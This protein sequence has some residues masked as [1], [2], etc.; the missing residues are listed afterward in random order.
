MLNV[1]NV[2]GVVVGNCDAVVGET[3]TYLSSWSFKSTRI[4]LNFPGYKI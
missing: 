3:H 4:S 2:P 1:H